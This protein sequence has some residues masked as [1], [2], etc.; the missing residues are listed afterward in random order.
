MKL[1]KEVK[2]KFEK[3]C[4]KE[5]PDKI[6]CS[7]LGNEANWIFVQAGSHLGDYLHYEFSENIVKLHIEGS[8]W[9]PI[10]N[11]LRNNL[12]SEELF[13]EYWYRQGCQ[14]VF[15]R[16]ITTEADM[17]EAFC[18]IRDII[19]PIIAQFEDTNIKPAKVSGES[20]SAAIISIQE[21]MQRTLVIP[22]YQR[23]YRWHYANVNLLLDDIYTSFIS[24]KMSYRIG[25]TILYDNKESSNYEIVDGQQRLTTLAIVLCCLNVKTNFLKNLTY[26]HTTSVKH[27]KE[28]HIF[29]KQWLSKYS[30]NE[31]T[32][33]TEYILTKCEFVEIVVCNLSEAF[34]MFDSQ[35]GRGKELEAYN[36]LKAYHIRAMEH[37]LE[38]V[39]IE[40]DKRWEA[41]TR[42]QFRQD[43]ESHDMLRQLFGEQLY[44]SRLWSRKEEANVFKKRDID[45]FKGFTLN[46][47]NDIQYPYQNPQLLE[48][49]T[50]KFYES[51][52]SGMIGT[53]N[54]FNTGDPVN[55]NP[56]VNINQ[57]IVNGK[58]FF[59]Y[60]ETYTEMYKRLFIDLD[61]Y[62]LKEFKEFYKE[63]CKYPGSHRVGD[64]YLR[65]VYKSLIFLV[66]DKFGEDGVIQSYKDIYGVIYRRRLEFAQIKYTSLT[67]YPSEFFALIRSAKSIS[68]LS[69]LKDMGRI[70]DMENITFKNCEKVRHYFDNINNV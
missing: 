52:L 63:Y 66:F 25:S 65:E 38:D 43:Q 50:S 41:S 37:D 57:S 61:N 64:R 11:Y 24:K 32:A 69:I 7:N 23:P 3:F 15:D 9:R 34:Q 59:D 22:D 55:M 2:H 49:I 54:R 36:L 30:Y 19:E 31:Q 58:P 13:S 33:L 26:N 56:F 53:K 28:N 4:A 68:E 14:W 29:I 45:E 1:T 10:R 18:R 5:F 70:V 51:V 62:E 39:K 12:T 27:I 16:E 60:I 47:N 35:N 67:K 46:K 42:F 20:I 6:I 8:S 40:C 48:F 21:L 17:Y 44:R